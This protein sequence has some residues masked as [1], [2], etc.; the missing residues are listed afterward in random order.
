MWLL[1]GYTHVKPGCITNCCYP[2]TGTKTQTQCLLLSIISNQKKLHLSLPASQSWTAV[3]LVCWKSHLP[4]YWTSLSPAL[5]LW[6]FQRYSH[7][8]TRPPGSFLGKLWRKS[9]SQACIN[10]HLRASLWNFWIREGRVRKHQIQISEGKNDM[11]Y[12]I[13]LQ[14]LAYLQKCSLYSR[15]NWEERVLLTFHRTDYGCLP[16]SKR[17]WKMRWERWAKLPCFSILLGS[18]V[19]HDYIP[20]KSLFQCKRVQWKQMPKSKKVYPAA[21]PRCTSLQCAGARQIS[22][23]SKRWRWNWKISIQSYSSSAQDIHGACLVFHSEH[24]D[25]FS[26]NGNVLFWF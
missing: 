1:V 10:C 26:V 3:E 5:A 23:L 14:T 25:V 6:H 7:L 13:A 15:D 20:R 12:N 19:T 24:T 9:C 21:R 4:W 2:S 11:R 22:R 17:S 18:R 8:A 16:A